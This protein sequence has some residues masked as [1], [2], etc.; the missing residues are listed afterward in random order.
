MCFAVCSHTHHTHMD[1]DIAV[2]E[3]F[4]YESNGTLNVRMAFHKRWAANVLRRAANGLCSFAKL[5][6]PDSG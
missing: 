2:N 3:T 4:R 1:M 5:F 6:A